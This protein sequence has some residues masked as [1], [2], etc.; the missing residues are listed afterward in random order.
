[1]HCAH[2]NASAPPYGF[3][4][5]MIITDS[6]VHEIDMAR[7]LFGEEITAVSI[8]LPRSSRRGGEDLRDPVLLLLELASGV[9]VD[10]EVFVNASY[11]YDIRGEVVCEQGTAAL[12]ETGGATVRAAGQRSGHLPADWR[13]R[14]TRAFDTEFA[15]WLTAVAAGPPTGPS[16]WDGYAATAVA[17]SCLA[18]L[19]TGQRTPVSLPGRPAFYATTT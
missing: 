7:W 12:G 9:L 14:F 11:G 18:A 2:R 13:E 19:R 4:T 8:R 3:T 1:M 10:V 16:S 17:E 5:D 6:A 15:E